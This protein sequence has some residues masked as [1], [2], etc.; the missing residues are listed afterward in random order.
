MADLREKVISAGFALFGATGIHRLAAPLTRGLGAILMFHHV[1]PWQERDFAPNRLLE[2]TPD[3]LDAALTRIRARGFEIVTL[4][5]ALQR[6]V[7]SGERPFVVLTFDDGYRDN[8]AHALPVLETHGAP[9]T[10]FVTSGFADRS[11]RL[12]W[13]ELE[14]AIR[15]LDRVAIDGFELA[16]GSAVEKERAHALLYRSLRAGPEERLLETCARLCAEAGIDPASIP[17]ALC[18]D[19]DSI[20]TLSQH[21]LATIGVHTLTH[22]MLA[23]HLETFAR[24]ELAE[25]RA[26]IEAAIGK[27]AHHLAYPVG[28]PN[29][30]GPREFAIARELGF[31]SAVTTRPGMI[32]P[33]HAAHA[34]AL[35]RLSVNGRYQSLD[36]LDILLSGAPFALW[37][38]GR[39]VNAA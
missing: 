11:A 20:R 14:E 18:L 39:R 10:M 8:V 24:T 1:R 33:E 3:F 7:A 28:D 36:M 19:W 27:P 22:P 4:D 30:A 17:A 34:T 38:R 29:S 37:N 25:S 6:I 12:W 23:K 2:I 13:V 5:T 31:A 32:F 21:P 35:P 9:F 15:R 16:T 26:R